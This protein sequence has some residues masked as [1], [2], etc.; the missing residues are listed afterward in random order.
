[1]VKYRSDPS[2]SKAVAFFAQDDK[3]GW[4]SL[5]QGDCNWEDFVASRLLNLD[6]RYT[7]PVIL[8]GDGLPSESKDPKL[9]D[10]VVRLT[11][12]FREF[13]NNFNGSR[14]LPLRVLS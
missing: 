2:T 9:V 7:P 4:L 14:L 6:F 5:L 11:A 8:S 12:E 3:L 13:S 10:V 1:M